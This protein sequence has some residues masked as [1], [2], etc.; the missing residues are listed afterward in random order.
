MSSRPYPPQHK[1]QLAQSAQDEEEA[2]KHGRIVLNE[3]RTF[4]ERLTGDLEEG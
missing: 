4:V 3:I 1:S 2:L